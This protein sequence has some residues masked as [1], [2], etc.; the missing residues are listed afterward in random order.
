MLVGKLLLSIMCLCTLFAPS[1]VL[2]GQSDVMN[3]LKGSLILVPYI[4][5]LGIVMCNFK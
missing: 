4:F 5:N 2:T 1:Q 3:H